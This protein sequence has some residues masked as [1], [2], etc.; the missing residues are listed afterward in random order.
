M[1]RYSN[2]NLNIYIPV[3]ISNIK[4]FADASTP[5]IFIYYKVPS[6]KLLI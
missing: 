3:Y 2:N 1:S 6:H 5:I 4:I